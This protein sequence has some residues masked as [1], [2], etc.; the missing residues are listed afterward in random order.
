[1]PVRQAVW[2]QRKGAYRSAAAQAFIAVLQEQ[3]VT[4]TPPAL[5]HPQ[6]MHQPEA[7][8]NQ[9]ADDD[10]ALAAAGI[11]QGEGAGDAAQ[12]VDEGN[13]NSA[14]RS[15]GSGAIRPAPESAYSDQINSTSAIPAVTTAGNFYPLPPP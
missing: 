6:Q 2:L 15:S 5:R 1:M 9:R 4:P 7:E 13:D 3:G 14:G 10:K 8:A 12:Q 11:A